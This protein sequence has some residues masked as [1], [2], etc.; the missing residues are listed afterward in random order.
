MLTQ[1]LALAALAVFGLVD[2]LAGRRQPAQ[3]PPV[4]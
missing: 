4:A 2:A 3:A 1:G